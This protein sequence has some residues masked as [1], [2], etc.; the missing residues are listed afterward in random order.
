MQ[1]DKKASLETLPRIETVSLSLSS[2][3]GQ[4]LLRSVADSAQGFEV[5]M[6]LLKNYRHITKKKTV[7]NYQYVEKWIMR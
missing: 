1:Q 2:R 3:N 5:C 6:V 7:D 4:S